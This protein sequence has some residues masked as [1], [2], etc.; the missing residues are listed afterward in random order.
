ML[1]RYWA[2]E[3]DFATQIWTTIGPAALYA[4]F[5]FLFHSWL[6]RCWCCSLDAPRKKPPFKLMYWLLWSGVVAIVASAMAL[7]AW[8]GL[9][10]VCEVGQGKGGA[11]HVWSTDGNV[12]VVK[13]L[14]LKRMFRSGDETAHLA[15]AT[16]LRT[17][18]LN[19]WRVNEIVES[20]GGRGKAYWLNRA[21]SGHPPGVAA[22][23][24]L[25]SWNP[26]ASRMLGL[27]VFL[28]CGVAAY[29]ACVMYTGD[30]ALGW[31]MAILF[32]FV[33][34]VQYWHA[35]RVSTDILPC[36]PSFLA[37]GVLGGILTSNDDTPSSHQMRS[38]VAMGGLLALACICTYTAFLASLASCAMLMSR[39]TTRNWRAI[40]VVLCPSAMA[41]LFGIWFSQVS[42]GSTSVLL[43]DRAANAVGTGP[44]FDSQGLTLTG[45]LAGL[46]QDL[47]PPLCTLLLVAAALRIHNVLARPGILMELLAAAA[48]AVPSA[49]M[50][51]P[52]LRF[53]F[54]GWLFVLT[55]LGVPDLLQRCDRRGQAF[56]VAT[57]A[58]FAT[59]KFVI[60][61]HLG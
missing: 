28:A 40:T 44:S 1:L 8:E 13:E 35:F 37:F 49:T 31:A 26:P 5:V 32:A 42:L 22:V 57:V 56:A 48:V 20:S 7:R 14:P 25:V 61:A 33:P 59:A 47:G 38:L 60:L 30:R 45:F 6:Q 55:G 21:L 34:E 4:G 10:S 15:A 52:Q 23:F 36:L 58:G 50:F 54:P 3:A 29:Q 24:S 51:W 41:V 2:R 18:G 27:L 17:A 11:Y 19:P 53:M 43:I 39:S 16:A 12:A 46:P 9:V